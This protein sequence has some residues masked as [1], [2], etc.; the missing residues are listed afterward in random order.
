MSQLGTRGLGLPLV[1][2]VAAVALGLGWFSGRRGQ[3]AS[4]VVTRIDRDGIKHVERVVASPSV[5]T[6]VRDLAR[7]E[8]VSFHMERVI[9]LEDRQARMFGM[10]PTKDT[11]LLV[12]AGDVLAGIDMA[13]LRDGDIVVE[14][15]TGPPAT[16]S[17]KMRL[18]PPEILS[19]TLDSKRT[20]V[21]SRK[22]GWFAKPTTDL[23][24]RARAHAEEAIRTGA[25][26]SGILER[27]RKNGASTLSALV[28]SLGYEKV[29]ISWQE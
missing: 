3:D 4:Q 10:V 12:A 9:D 23:E 2:L 26:E 28:R 5:L 11:I 13:K 7:L 21:H 16:H 1:V 8:S 22:T 20:Y 15:V 27:A 14:D 17:V 19:V 18:P 24:A 29:E 6:A 25:L